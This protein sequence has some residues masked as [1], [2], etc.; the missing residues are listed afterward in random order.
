MVMH[1]LDMNTINTLDMSSVCMWRVLM[2]RWDGGGQ[3]A[4]RSSTASAA[5]STL[6]HIE[7]TSVK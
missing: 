6:L 4:G 7:K 1:T 3:T 5:S 2:W